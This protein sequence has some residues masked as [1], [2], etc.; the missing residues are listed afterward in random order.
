MKNIFTYI[1]II[2]IFSCSSTKQEKRLIGNWYTASE[3][4]IDSEFEFHKDSLLIYNS[5]GKT[6]LKWKVKDQKIYSTYLTENGPT[7]KYKID[8]NNVFLNLELIGDNGFILPTLIKAKSPFDFFQKI[9][10]M[11]I[12]LPTT[13]NELEYLTQNNTNYNIYAGYKNNNL[14]V[15]TD[16]SSD[17]NNLDYEVNEFIENSR[18]ELKSFL[19]FNLIA[20]K[21]IVQSKIDSIKYILKKTSIK[22]IYRTYKNEQIDYDESINWFGKID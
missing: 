3:N 14:I 20:D 16:K 22:P 8:E 10:D 1:F 4:R 7:Y 21:N 5:Y 15:K 2:F 9:I 19:K 12:E 17:L 13:E 11:D 18:D 6:A